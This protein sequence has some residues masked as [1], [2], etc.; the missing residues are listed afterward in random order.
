MD[1]APRWLQDWARRY[2]S[3][4][5]A[6]PGGNPTRVRDADDEQLR[7]LEGKL[8]A[9]PRIYGTALNPGCGGARPCPCCLPGRRAP[10]PC[11]PLRFGVPGGSGPGASAEPVFNPV[12]LKVTARP[13]KCPV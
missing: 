12:M 5:G 4:P 9:R 11:A 3:R 10:S 13:G 1:P 6:G 2:E 8:N 7:V